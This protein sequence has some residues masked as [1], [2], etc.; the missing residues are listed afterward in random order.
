M[1]RFLRKVIRQYGKP[2]VVTLVKR[3]TSTATLAMLSAAN[4]EEENITVR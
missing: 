4:P 3:G 2:E 1:F